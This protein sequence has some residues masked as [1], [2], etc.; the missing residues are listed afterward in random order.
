MPLNN[1]R[2]SSGTERGSKNTKSELG[3]VYDIILDESNENIVK[4]EEDGIK[5]VGGIR[6]RLASDTTASKS[7]LQIAYPKNLNY[8]SLPV[9][10]EYVEITRGE[11]GNFLYERV[12][13]DISPNL[14][15]SDNSISSTYV[16]DSK[17][18]TS[19][20]STYSRVSSTGISRSNTDNGKDFD[21]HGDYF[22]PQLNIHKLKLYE[23]D[24]LIE[25]R[26]GQSIRFSGYNNAEN[27]FSPT[28]IIR[29]NESALSKTK[30]YNTTTEE[31]VNRD[32]TII[33]LGSGEYVLQF[34]PGTVS[35]GGSSDFETKPNTF[36][37]YP[38]ELKGE[39]LL[40]N[41]GRI[42]LSAKTGEF[43]VYS[44]KNYGFISDGSLSIDNKLGIDITVGDN[45]NVNTADRDVNINSGNGKINLGNNNLESI[46]R[47]ETLV[48]LM[49]QLIDALTQQVFLTP[50]GPSATG[51]T[52]IATFEKIKSQL[53]TML[54]TLNKTS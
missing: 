37:T 31:D 23:G 25:S 8:K 17:S 11:S 46:V 36:K 41:S 38:S 1:A 54:S 34:Q 6:F 39:Q 9:K 15:S 2:I 49:T 50:S 52:N 43:I 5:M 21:G 10:N 53:N 18:K 48:D 27:T 13:V 42:I 35:D 44:K 14:N 3:V 33:L 32:G 51:P 20:A 12:G 47:G 24:S 40:L 30:D 7:K 19:S 45:I 4:L 28:L 16:E 22:E 29:N 26:F